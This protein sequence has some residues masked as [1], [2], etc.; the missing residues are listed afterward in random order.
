MR[1]RDV[2]VR[3]PRWSAFVAGAGIGLV[4]ALASVLVGWHTVAIESGVGSILGWL[5][6]ALFGLA[7][8]VA[9]FF[10]VQ[11]HAGLPCIPDGVRLPLTVLTV[12][13]VSGLAAMAIT[14]VFMNR[15]RLL[16]VPLGVVAVFFFLVMNLITSV[17][18]AP[19]L[20]PSM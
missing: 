7:G 20:V 5:D 18:L 14:A 13:A 4:R 19:T 9:F 15:D 2:I 1:I 8:T 12:A 11:H 17:F 10:M 3:F 16:R 6:R